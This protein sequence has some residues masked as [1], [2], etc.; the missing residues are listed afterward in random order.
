MPMGVVSDDDLAKELE[1]N[2]SNDAGCAKGI[3]IPEII[4]LPK[5]GRKEGDTNVPEPLRNLIAQEHL[6][7]G[8][9][10]AVELAA[11]F[12]VS[13]SSVS[14]YANGATS[15][16]S[17]NKKDP[18]L[19]SHIAQA[20]QRIAGKARRKLNMALQEITPQK[21]EE[22]SLKT[23]ASVAKDMAVIIKQMEPENDNDNNQHTNVQVVLF[24]PPVV[25]ES[26]FPRVVAKE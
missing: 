17:Y 13:P 16:A 19:K 15:T 4:E 5:R 7:N 20:K 18:A 26:S 10:S 24:A 6:E 11:Q 8:R 12:G 23:L 1:N 21:M 14:A 3:I 22:A 9:Q 25:D 2:G